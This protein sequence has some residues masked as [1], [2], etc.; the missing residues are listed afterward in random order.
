MIFDAHTHVWRRWPYQPPVPDPETRGIAG[1][2]LYQMDRH[3]VDRA[4][5]IAASLGGSAGNADYPF[6]E[7]EASGGRLMVFPDLECRWAPEF[8]APGA[9]DRLAATRAGTG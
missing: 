9:A 8:R 6:A 2:L 5:V 1:Q 3:E 4:V 7:A